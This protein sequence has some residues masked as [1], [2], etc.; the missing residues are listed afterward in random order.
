MGISANPEGIPLSADID[1]FIEIP[2]GMRWECIMC[3]SCCGNVFSRKWIDIH[4]SEK[5]G[6]PVDGF[7]KYLD[8]G[9]GNR[10][11][12]YET[13]P[14]ICRGYPFIIKKK[15]D[16]YILTVHNKCPGI[17]KGEVL[18]TESRLMKD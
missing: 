9:N 5:V 8:R 11:G 15:G 1:D 2:E 16:H 17:G 4:L 7:C 3:G 6:D 10:C 12:R 14:N 13:R 18:D